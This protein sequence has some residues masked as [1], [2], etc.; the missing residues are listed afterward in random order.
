M[1][2]HDC[3][4]DTPI[5]LLKASECTMQKEIERMREHIDGSADRHQKIMNAISDMKVWVLSGA[6]ASMFAV[7]MALVFK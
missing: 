5:A 6:A 4:Q 1:D 7:I 3:K 2:D